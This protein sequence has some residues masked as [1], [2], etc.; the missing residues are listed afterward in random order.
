M[1]SP[2]VVM[3]SNHTP[4]APILMGSPSS[5][6]LSPGPGLLKSIASWVKDNHIHT[7]PSIS[8]N[9]DDDPEWSHLGIAPTPMLTPLSRSNHNTP[10]PSSKLDIS[11]PG[12][13]IKIAK[14]DQTTINQTHLPACHGTTLEESDTHPPK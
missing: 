1:A 12:I 3:R 13:N 5:L 6:G 14:H 4:V 2:C 8:P 11:I 7:R 9:S 10:M